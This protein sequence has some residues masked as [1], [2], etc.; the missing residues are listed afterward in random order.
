MRDLAVVCSHL[1]GGFGE[2]GNRLSSKVHSGRMPSTEKTLRY[3]LCDWPVFSERLDLKHPEA[4]CPQVTLLSRSP[5][6][7]DRSNA[8]SHK[9]LGI[10]WRKEFIILSEIYT[11]VL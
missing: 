10:A 4:P 1:R 7:P 5:D 9:M 2:G 6:S 3:L 8:A 11:A